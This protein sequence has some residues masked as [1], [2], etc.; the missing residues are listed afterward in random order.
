M[1]VNVCV[2]VVVLEVFQ[3][4]HQKCL[5]PVFSIPCFFNKSLS[6]MDWWSTSTGMYVTV[7]V[8]S[9]LH[10]FYFPLQY[11]YISL[12]T[13]FSKEGILDKTFLVF[14]SYPWTYNL[15]WWLMVIV[16]NLQCYVDLW[17]VYLYF[18]S[19]IYLNKLW[20]LDPWHVQEKILNG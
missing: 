10:L 13:I 9:Y 5:A 3:F 11:L 18:G 4:H 2:I 14:W 8:F 15:Q 19:E 12:F 17:I 20:S 1:F 6:E 7:D 16:L